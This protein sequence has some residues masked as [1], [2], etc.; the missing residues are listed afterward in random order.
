MWAA[1][2]GFH[3]VVEFLL[4]KG[5]ILKAKDKDYQTVLHHVAIYG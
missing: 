3:D 1:M 4:D 5:A 2:G